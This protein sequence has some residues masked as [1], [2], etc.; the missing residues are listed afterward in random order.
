[1]LPDKFKN[2]GDAVK[3][4]MDARMTN[5]SPYVVD[6]V[7]WRVFETMAFELVPRING[8]VQIIYLCGGVG[9]LKIVTDQLRL[10]VTTVI[11]G[12]SM[13]LPEKIILHSLP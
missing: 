5:V 10:P 7:I 6:P 2:W 13:I 12:L 8:Y 11:T 1:M 4:V 3:A 9:E